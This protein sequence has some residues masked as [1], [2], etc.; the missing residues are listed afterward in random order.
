MHREVELRFPYS[1][2]NGVEAGINKNVKIILNIKIYK[3]IN[4]FSIF[5]MNTPLLIMNIIYLFLKYIIKFL[6]HFDLVYTFLTTLF[7]LMNLRCKLQLLFC[8]SFQT[9]RNF[10]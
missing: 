8:M 7:V 2:Y 10:F 4:H 6:P 3:K 1:N 9:L 5:F